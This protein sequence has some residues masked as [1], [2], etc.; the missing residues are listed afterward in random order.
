MIWPMPMDT[1]QFAANLLR[2]Y[3]RARRDLPW[4]SPIGSDT[5]PD[6]Y[7]VLVSEIMLQQTQVAT[8]TPYFLRFMGRF[9][10]VADLASAPSQEVLRLWQGLG[11]YSRARHLQ[12]AAKGIVNRFAGRVPDDPK[13][14]LELPGVGRYT[15]GAVASIA[16]GRRAAVLDGNVARVVCRLHLVR[17]SPKSPK[18]HSRLWNVVAQMLPVSDVGEF[19]SALME[20][21]RDDLHAPITEMLVVPGAGFL[22][23]RSGWGAGFDSKCASAAQDSNRSPLDILH[24]P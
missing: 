7:A 1:G 17:E 9:P 23:G 19:N 11:Y 18:T 10:T 13:D 22:P 21:G 14:L 8:V 3:G 5:P 24:S 15:A 2:W 6:P 12:E 20:L 4:R 16:F